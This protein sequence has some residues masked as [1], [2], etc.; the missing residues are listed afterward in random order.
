M[1][2][3]E[4]AHQG[5]WITSLLCSSFFLCLVH[6]SDAFRVFFVYDRAIVE[7][8]DCWSTKLSKMPARSLWI[9][10]LKGFGHFLIVLIEDWE[11]VMRH[12]AYE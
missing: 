6:F 2:G 3:T 11:A 9:P 7:S 1:G 12:W 10:K 5:S 4:I 8:R